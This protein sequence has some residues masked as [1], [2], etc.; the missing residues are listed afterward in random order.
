MYL[1]PYLE[2]S[3]PEHLDLYSSSLF[4]FQSKNK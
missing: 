1:G 2:L 4:E 3:F